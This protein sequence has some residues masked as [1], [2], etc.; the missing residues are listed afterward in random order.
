MKKFGLLMLV[1]MILSVVLTGCSWASTL[2]FFDAVNF[3]ENSAYALEKAESIDYVGEI[4]ELSDFLMLTKDESDIEKVTM[5]VYNLQTKTVVYEESYRLVPVSDTDLVEID[6]EIDRVMGIPKSTNHFYVTRTYRSGA[7]DSSLYNLKGENLLAEETDE[8]GFVFCGQFL[9]K[10]GSKVYKIGGET[11]ELL[12]DFDFKGIS[13]LNLLN[14]LEDGGKYYVYIG[15]SLNGEIE[16]VNVYDSEFNFKDSV[17]LELGVA[18][19]SVDYFVLSN[20]NIIAVQQRTMSA[21]ACKEECDYVIGDTAYIV[22]TYLVNLRNGSVKQIEDFPVDNIEIIPIQSPVLDMYENAPY[23]FKSKYKNVVTGS[24]VADGT[25][26]EKECVYFIDNNG[27]L[28]GEYEGFNGEF[29]FNTEVLGDYVIFNEPNGKFVYNTDGKFVSV[30]PSAVE[31]KNE[32]WFAFENALYTYEGEK[33]YEYGDSQTI[34]GCTSELFMF[35]EV[36]AATGTEKYT[37]YDGEDI[38]KVLI[39]NSVA[40]TVNVNLNQNYFVVNEPSKITIYDASGEKVEELKDLTTYTYDIIEHENRLFIYREKI[41][42]GAKN[43]TIFDF[44]KK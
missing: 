39:N 22:N 26:L 21:S 18:G 4:E 11:P 28:V 16:Y 32:K 12:C 38:T 34:V 3:R 8:V 25:V 30:M 37:I 43:I 20:G 36:S 10:M 5:R 35:V 19:G 6:V 15:D 13:G 1:V 44:V 27:A 29:D 42:D 24:K 31:A 9:L 17:K 2:D 33:V 41:D 14:I 23:G 40:G 7:S